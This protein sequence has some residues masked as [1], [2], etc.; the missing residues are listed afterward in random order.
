MS[1][2]ELI[3]FA[4]LVRRESSFIS[5][6]RPYSCEKGLGGFVSETKRYQQKHR[7]FLL[8]IDWQGSIQCKQL[9]GR[10]AATE[11]E[12][13]FNNVLLYDIM[14]K[15]H[16]SQNNQKGDIGFSSGELKMRILNWK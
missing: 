13:A 5:V 14:I 16:I 9:E 4:Y 3:E 10:A 15:F 7:I 1:G 11:M 6:C 12:F 8:S 2:L